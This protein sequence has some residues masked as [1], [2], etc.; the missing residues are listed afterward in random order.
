M[1]T[2]QRATVMTPTASFGGNREG[3]THAVKSVEVYGYGHMWTFVCGTV[4][5]NAYDATGIPS[6]PVDCKRCLKA[7]RAIEKAAGHPCFE[8]VQG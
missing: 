8:R 1:T 2:P 3:R 7:Q 6:A 4:T 5:E